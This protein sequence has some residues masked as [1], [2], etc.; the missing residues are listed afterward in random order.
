M[1]IH[2]GR[3]NSGLGFFLKGVNDPNIS[4][5]FN[6]IE[7]SESVSSMSESYFEH[8]APST[9]LNGLALS[10]LLPSAAIVS[11]L[12]IS[13]CTSWGNSSKSLRAALIHEIGRVFLT[14][15]VGIFVTTLQAPLSHFSGPLSL[16]SFR[17]LE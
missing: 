2:L 9:P 6:S 7:Y 13:P 15:N 3:F 1:N 16:S 17:S 10:D 11:A 14:L 12:S 4:A 5:D 8:A